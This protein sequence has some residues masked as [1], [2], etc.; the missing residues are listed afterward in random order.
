M[1]RGP[2]QGA[3]RHNRRP[4]SANTARRET[5]RWGGVAETVVT[6]IKRANNTTWQPII[7]LTSQEVYEWRQLLGLSQREFSRLLGYSSP[8]VGLWERGRKP[9]PRHV[10]SRF[11][12]LV[13]PLMWEQEEARRR[14]GGN[15][16]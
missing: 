14:N 5:E 8:V 3:R 10:Y 16:K 2:N 9:V 12:N 4:N 13:L 15:S 6:R 7:L 11:Y 1:W